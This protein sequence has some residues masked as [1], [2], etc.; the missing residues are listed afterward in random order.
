MMAGAHAS[1]DL[2]SWAEKRRPD[3]PAGRIVGDNL[4]ISR[5]G[6]GGFGA[7][8][9]ALSLRDPRPRAIKLLLPSLRKNPTSADRFRLEGRIGASFDHPSLVRVLE[10]GE[11][12]FGPYIE[13]ELVKGKTLAALLGRGSRL[14]PERT[15]PLIRQAAEAL[16]IVHRAGFVHRDVKPANMMI[17]IAQDGPRGRVTL[18]DFGLTSRIGDPVHEVGEGPAGTPGYIAPEEFFTARADP[19]ADIYALGVALYQMI[20]GRLPFEGDQQEILKQ[21]LTGYPNPLQTADGLDEIAF[22]M[23]ERDPK[24]RPTIEQVIGALD[25]RFARGD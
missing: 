9:R 13:M 17:S 19:A 1:V 11:S 10:V 2:A 12:S 20:S 24:A 16:S 23:L 7:V 6:D 25:I 3:D 21:Q 14:S 22:W 15:A 4:V 18:I 5:I 8:Y